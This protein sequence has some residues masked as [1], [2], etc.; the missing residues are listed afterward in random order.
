MRTIKEKKIGF[1]ILCKSKKQIFYSY[2]FDY[3]SQTCKNKWTFKECED[4]GHIQ[5]DPRPSKSELDTIY[6]HNYYSY[7]LS[8][9]ITPFIL[10]GKNFLDQ[11]KINLIIKNLKCELRS[12][13]DV[14]CGDGKFL[15]LLEKKYQIKPEKIYGVELNEGLV[16]QLKKEN[17]VAINS[18]IENI[19][20]IK[21]SSISL[22]T[23]FHVIEHVSDPKIVIK[24]LS[25]WLSK[26]GV[27]AIETPNVSSIDAQLFGKTFWGGYHFPRHWHLFNEKTL[28]KLLKECGINPI[29]ISYQTGHSFW[30]F[31][32]HHLALYNFKNKKIAKLFNPLKSILLL[33]FFTL[34]DKTRAFLG[35]KTSSILII[36]QKI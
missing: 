15:K 28:S 17:Y 35:A 36:G 27:L 16:K 6:P 10:A 22:I 32:F 3:E 12:Y 33:I 20:R 14:G 25:K 4:C 21:T 29:K 26:G 7:E 13:M 11:I 5:L 30:M 24:K 1:C 9:K 2:G 31:S 23:M 34:F 18:S 19:K 8:N